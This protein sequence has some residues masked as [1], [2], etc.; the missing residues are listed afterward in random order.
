M[1]S[2]LGEPLSMIKVVE[3]MKDYDETDHKKTL[4]F[5]E[6]AA[7]MLYALVHLENTDQ[8]KYGQVLKT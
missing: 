6:K 5:K 7:E 3:G 8:A 1:E 2:H 4:E